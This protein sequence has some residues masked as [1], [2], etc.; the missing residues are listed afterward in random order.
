MKCSEVRKFLDS[1]A[2]RDLEP[3]ESEVFLEHIDSCPE[4][5]KIYET[6]KRPIRALST[7][8]FSSM[9]E[10]IPETA[11]PLFWKGLE[12]SVLSRI[13]LAPRR[14]R[15]GWAW[16]GAGFAAA[17]GIL[18]ALWLSWPGQGPPGVPD[19]TKLPSMAGSPSM[20]NLVPVKGPLEPRPVHGVETQGGAVPVEW[21][22]FPRSPRFRR[23][24]KRPAE[25]VPVV[26]QGRF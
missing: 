7:L 6:R 22:R 24:G 17:A 15:M 1:L 10:E 11:S 9:E 13:A 14:E 19:G 5:R 4:C 21:F 3:R 18:L 26:N 23:P 16:F 12:R 25:A 20:G 2:G 8:R